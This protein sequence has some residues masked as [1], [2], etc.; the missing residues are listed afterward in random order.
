M[1]DI[2]TLRTLFI[3]GI[4]N[5]PLFL[6]AQAAGFGDAAKS[7]RICRAGEA[8]PGFLGQP[9]TLTGRRSAT[10]TFPARLTT[11][12]CA[13]DI[14][15]LN[16]PEVTALGQRLGRRNEFVGYRVITTDMLNP[17]IDRLRTLD[18]I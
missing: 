1:L 13:N 2:R 9:V 8:I 14:A 11:R 6:L 10:R 7:S 12:S 16:L 4:P 15:V 18:P 5:E 17:P 3:A